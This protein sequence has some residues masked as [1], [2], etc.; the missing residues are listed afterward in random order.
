MVFEKCFA[1]NNL[2]SEIE[3]MTGEF[4]TYAGS[5]E[6]IIDSQMVKRTLRGEK[7]SDLRMLRQMIPGILVTV[8]DIDNT[9]NVLGIEYFKTSTI[10]TDHPIFNLTDDLW[11][12]TYHIGDTEPS[13]LGYH[14]AI[15]GKNQRF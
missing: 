7:L 15:Y 1:I 12:R 6:Q 11:W 13:V 10:E 4:K 3:S 2:H 14:Q 5:I 8:G 9:F